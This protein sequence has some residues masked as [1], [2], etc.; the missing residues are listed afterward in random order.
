M[1][2]EKQEYSGD[3]VNTLKATEQ[4]EREEQ[5]YYDY[6]RNHPHMKECAKA[7]LYLREN[8][9]KFEKW[10]VMNILYNYEMEG[11]TFLSDFSTIMDVNEFMRLPK[12]LVS[13]LSSIEYNIVDDGYLH[14]YEI[15]VVN[16]IKSLCKEKTLKNKASFH[17]VLS[18]IEPTSAKN[19]YGK[20]WLSRHEFM[21]V[22]PKYK[23]SKDT[24]FKTV[25]NFVEFL[26]IL[27]DTKNY[28]KNGYVKESVLKKYFKNLVK[29]NKI[30]IGG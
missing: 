23:C 15:Q 7:I 13:M 17:Y 4:Y 11:D 22:N 19:T 9:P 24:W 16:D 28:T 5:E 21:F 6:L 12:A 10:D 25:D 20:K 18:A 2:E 8:L 27:S 1:A 30:G 26:K 29:S 14:L 3:F